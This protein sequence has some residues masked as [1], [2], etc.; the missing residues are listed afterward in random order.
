MERHLRHRVYL[1]VFGLIVAVTGLGAFL[2]DAGLVAVIFGLRIGRDSVG[3]FSALAL[4][5]AGVFFTWAALYLAGELRD[6]L[7]GR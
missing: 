6:E 4:I 7:R 1:A 2:L 5:E 3:I